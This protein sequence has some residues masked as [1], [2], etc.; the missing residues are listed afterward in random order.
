MKTL[1]EQFLTY[2]NNSPTCFHAVANIEEELKGKG[3]TELREEAE[4]NIEF[5]GSYYVKRNDSAIISFHLPKQSAN[6]FHMIASHC[7][8]PCFRL[9]ENAEIVVE[10][11][12]VKLNTEK[13]GGMIHSTWLDRPLSVAG[14][15]I[16][17]GEKGLE[18]KLVHIDRDLLVIPNVAI[19]MSREMNKGIEY[20]AQTDMLPLFSGIEGKN[21]FM[22]LIAKSADVLKEDI[23][24]SD[25]FV[26]ARDKGTFVGLNQEYIMAPRI[27]DLQC[28]Y[29]S[30][31]GFLKA[32]P[33]EKIA[34]HIV[35]DNEEVGSGT[36]QGA[37]STFLKDCLTR[38]CDAL[39]MTETEYKRWLTGSFLISAD[40]AHGVHPN[41]GE[42]ADVTNKPFL[43][44][45]IVIKYN[46]SQKYATDGYS[47]A[48]VKSYCKR[49]NIPVQTYANRSDIAG[50]STLGNISTSQVS[51]KSADIGLAQLAMHSACETAGSKD[52]AYLEE[53]TQIFLSE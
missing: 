50:G 25:L 40:N 42:K 48:V 9:K 41:H 1:T 28:V 32:C 2:V 31:Q 38:I 52:I 19:H 17:Q 30:L 23:L 29:G 33:K 34:V 14:R 5:D 21:Q 20:N 22:E 6:G 8:A 26:Y 49:G 11:Q 45:G 44:G 27:D 24:G 10:D 43:N 36:K 12:Y 46:G 15:I 53:L 13:Y 51:V 3:F 4:W 16:V 37:A 39:H 35:F 47:G 18:T 7:D